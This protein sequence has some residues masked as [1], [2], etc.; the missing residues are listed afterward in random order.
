MIFSG[1]AEIIT[2]LTQSVVE[3]KEA[4]ALLILEQIKVRLDVSDLDV[5]L[6]WIE[7]APLHRVRVFQHH[8]LPRAEPLRI[9]RLNA[10]PAY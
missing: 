6:V 2:V 8:Q 7:R 1:R 5:S 9:K 4:L 10:P 3:I